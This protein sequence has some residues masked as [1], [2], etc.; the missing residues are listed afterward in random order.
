MLTSADIVKAAGDGDALAARIWKETCLYLAVAC[1]NIQHTLNPQCIVLGG[2]LINA[3]AHL[4]DPL[5]E[6]VSGLVWTIAQDAPKI[7]FAT[8]GDDAG[9]IG[10]AALAREA[11]RME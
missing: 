9:V 10:A 6:T 1:V 5:R 3:G 11:A 8:L 4:M 7:V 2:G